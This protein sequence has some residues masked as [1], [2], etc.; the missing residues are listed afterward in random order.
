MKKLA[1][2]LKAQRVTEVEAVISDFTGIARGKIMPSSKFIAE[3]GIRLP[4]S[5]LIQGVTGDYVDDEIYYELMNAAEIDMILKPDESAVHKVPWALEPTALVIHDCYDKQGNLISMAPRAVLKNV[6][7]L[8]EAKGWKPVVAPELEFYL[9]KRTA[10][11][12]HPLQPPV[13]R[14]G[15]PES[16]RQ[17]Y[18]I[19]AANEYDPLFEDVYDWCEQQGL[20]VDTLIHE[21]GAAQMEINFRHGDALSLADQVFIFKRTVREAALKHE[22]NATFMAKP[23]SGE[24]GSSMHLHQSILDQQGNNIFSNEDGSPSKMIYHYIGGLQQYVSE[25]MPLFAPNVNSYRR[26]LRDTSAPVN[27]AWG[28]DNRTVSLRIPD[29]SPA[30]RRVE[31]RLAGAD[32]NP[33]LAFAASLLCGY[34]GMVNA[35]EPTQAVTGNASDDSNDKRLPLNLEEALELMEQSEILKKTL[36]RRFVRSYVEVKR[37]E[38]QNFKEIISSWEREYLQMTV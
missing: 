11:P 21:E 30:N 3:K 4:E 18:S 32:A 31:N 17:S 1:S 13:G 36:G 37:T 14:S 20:D 26:F 19:D 23:I 28:I 7:A 6:L 38:Y 27:L 33:Y 34:L 22:I 12:D 8:Y 25:A 16:G 9:T 2:W 35:A 29:S 24:P 5:L 15:R 10:N